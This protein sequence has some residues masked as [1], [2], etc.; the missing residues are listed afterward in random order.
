MRRSGEGFGA[1]R[2]TGALALL[3]LV[4][5]GCR[6]TSAVGAIGW[7]SRPWPSPGD[8]ELARLNDEELF[9]KGTAAFGGE[10]Y[11]QAARYFDRIVDFH[12]AS[13]HRPAALF[14][15]GLSYERLEDWEQ[16]WHR[17]SELA[18]PAKGTGDALES[19]FRSATMLYM[20]GRMD[21]A[22]SVLDLLSRRTDLPMTRQLQAL[23][24]RG[25]CEKE[26]G[27]LQKA[28]R[29]LREVLTRFESVADPEEVDDYF[30]A[31]AQFHLAEI[32]RLHYLAVE[33]DPSK[34]VQQ[35]TKDLDYK[36]E[37]LLSAQGHYLRC[38]RLGHGEWATA[39]GAQVGALY[40]SLW[41]AMADSA[42]PPELS[43]EEGKS[44]ARS[45]ARRS[46][47]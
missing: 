43:S 7:T 33:L 14:N 29:T 38:I 30:P 19:S 45:C 12:P 25:V 26:G 5:S 24:E 6:T 41:D 28:E 16:A 2:W 20:L 21:E 34:G 22:A 23:V 11:V 1:A 39:A 37:L 17:Y 27:D 10:D 3:L 15:A 9:A 44:T 18:N 40:E 13:R 47:C 32:Y 4:A 42:V 35:L 46:G 8:L 31:Q 36:S